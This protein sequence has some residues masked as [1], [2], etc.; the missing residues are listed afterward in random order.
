[1]ALADALPLLQAPM[2]RLRELR[3][4]VLQAGARELRALA[5]QLGRLVGVVRA[6]LGLDVGGAD[7]A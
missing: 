2:P 5:R 1:V 3:V 7:E 4:P 6:Q